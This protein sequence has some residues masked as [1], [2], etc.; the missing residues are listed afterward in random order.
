MADN[1]F[2]TPFTD[3]IAT[4]SMDG[5]VIS[6]RGGEDLGEGN[7]K[8]TENSVSGLPLLPNRW[9]PGGSDAAPEGPVALPDLMT[10]DRTIKTGR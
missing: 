4:P 7:Q 5:T 6:R 1:V 10:A 2:Q 9:V 8:E 3:A